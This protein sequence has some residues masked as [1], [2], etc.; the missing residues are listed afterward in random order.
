MT[1]RDQTSFKPL[2]KPLIFQ[3]KVQ[4]ANPDHT[5]TA[6]KEGDYKLRSSKPIMFCTFTHRP[7][8]SNMVSLTTIHSCESNENS[9]KVAYEYTYT[10]TYALTTV[11]RN[12]CYMYK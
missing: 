9:N 11:G 1:Y 5:T 10:Y 2:I 6:W 3:L 4:C 12:S 8:F 7:D